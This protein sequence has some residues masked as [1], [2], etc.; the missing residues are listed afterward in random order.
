MYLFQESNINYENGNETVK[1]S[2]LSSGL[3]LILMTHTITSYIF[4]Y[5]IAKVFAILNVCITFIGIVNRAVGLDKIKE[6]IILILFTFLFV[7]FIYSMYYMIERALYNL[8]VQSLKS[9]N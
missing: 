7:I 4:R 8:E 3:I 6:H 1:W 5:R 2:T 9:V